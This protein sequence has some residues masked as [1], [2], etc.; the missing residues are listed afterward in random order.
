MPGRGGGDRARRRG[1]DPDVLRELCKLFSDFIPTF[2]FTARRVPE[3]PSSAQMVAALAPQSLEPAP[4]SR[5][6]GRSGRGPAAPLLTRR[7]LTALETR[8]RTRRVEIVEIETDR[9][10][11]S[12]RTERILLACLL[13]DG[14]TRGEAAPV[15][16][17]TRRA[18][19]PRRG[20][21]GRAVG[22]GCGST[23]S[24]S[25]RRG[26]RGRGPTVGQHLRRRGCARLGRRGVGRP[27]AGGRRRGRA[28][29]I[30]TPVQ[31]Q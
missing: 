15:A 13:A 14:R 18:H 10:R 22:A 4:R 2:S 20:V 30:D 17:A 8:R 5:S 3:R 29:S 28:C 21:E 12:R 19:R 31:Q 23:R 27:G 7:S 16:E 6:V 11:V 24:G 1:S 9:A 26:R 25:V